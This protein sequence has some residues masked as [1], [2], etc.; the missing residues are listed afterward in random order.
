MAREPLAIVRIQ[1]ADAAP[2]FVEAAIDLL[3]EVED[4]DEVLVPDSVAECAAT[5][6]AVIERGGW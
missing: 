1:L 4:A 6:R 2:A 5:L 3:C